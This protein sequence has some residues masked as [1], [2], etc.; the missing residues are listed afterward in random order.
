MPPLPDHPL[1]WRPSDFGLTL[2]GVATCLSALYCGWSW[3]GFGRLLWEDWAL[4]CGIS[5]PLILLVV[6]PAAI[7][8]CGGL[9]LATGLRGQSRPG[10]S[11]RHLYT[12]TSTMFWMTLPV[13]LLLSCG[14]LSAFGHR[15]GRWGLKTISRG[16]GGGQR[17]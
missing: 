11:L 17:R 7:S 10:I 16:Q 1:D 2:T 9:A 8:I 13:A 12:I 3:L 6:G 5:W 4:G 15:A 14:A